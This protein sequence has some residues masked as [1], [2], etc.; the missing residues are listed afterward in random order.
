MKNP[1]NPSFGIQ[2]TVLL[3]RESLITRL[4]SD[5]KELDTPYRTTL[6]YGTRGI[7]K[8]VFMNEVGKQINDQPDWLAL[9]LIIGDNMVGRLVELLYQKATSPLQKLLNQISGVTFSIGGISINDS[10]RQLSTTNYQ[11]LLEKMLKILKEHHQHVL[12]MIDE[13]QDIPGMV[14]LA[15]VYQV[16]ISEDLPISIIMTGLPKNVQELQNNHVLTFLLRSGRIDLSPLNFFDIRAKYQQEL[17]KRDPQISKEVIRRA[18]QL[19]DGYAYAFQLM[20]YLLWQSPDKHITNETIDE[21]LPQ[22]Q[23]QLSRNAYSK[24]LE[25]LSPIDQQFI[26]IM[27]NAPEYPVSA[28]YLGK[29]LDQNPG[30]I[31]VYRRRLIDSQIIV[32][33]GYG[34]V[35]FALPLFKDFLLEDGQYMV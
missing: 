9:H 6:I 4:V 17:S 5:I 24:M 7:G 33:A 13:A 29:K 18:A 28:K 16:L 32:P 15:S 31:G 12:V 22:Y 11:I 26:I 20:G 10:P 19:A 34:R 3:N 1:F 2:P 14:E 23:A 27:A 25:E 35:K 21:V 8:T 30:Y